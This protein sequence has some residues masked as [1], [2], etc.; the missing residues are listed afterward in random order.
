MPMELV[1]SR[2]RKVPLVHEYREEM[3]ID[4]VRDLAHTGDVPAIIFVFG[5]EQC[6]EVAR[7]LKSCRRFTTDEEK[8]KVEALCDEALLPAG[9][10]KELRPLLAPRH[11][12]P[13][14]R[15]PAALQAARRAARARALDQ[16]RGVDRDDRRGHQPAGAHGRVPVAAQVHQAAGAAGHGRRVSPDGGSRR[17]PAVRRPRASRSRSRPSRSSAISKKELKDAAKRPAYDEARS[18]SA[19]TAARA[20]MRSAR[21]T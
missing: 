10:A 9:C 3:M 11:R 13:P 15:H 4:T 2:E 1:D 6:F 8:A 21:A 14:R 12:H 19:C 16:V 17:A 7:L 5:R 18:R 20:T